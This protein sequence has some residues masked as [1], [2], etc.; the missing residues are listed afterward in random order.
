MA[1][2]APMRLA[3]RRAQAVRIG[4]RQDQMHVVGHQAV[5][6]HRDARRPAALRQQR[7]ICG[8]V[9]VVEEDLLAPVAALRHMMRDAGCD[10]PRQACHERRVATVRGCVKSVLC[11]QN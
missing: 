1:R 3:E 9:V 10:D 4:R 6:P 7:A 8:V 5:G 11:P 2:I